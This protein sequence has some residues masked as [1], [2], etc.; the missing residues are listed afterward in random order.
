[1]KFQN[2][3]LI[4]LLLP[5]MVL[6]G[7]SKDEEGVPESENDTL[8]IS[9]AELVFM[10]RDTKKSLNIQSNSEWEITAEDDS[11]F[12]VSQTQG[13]G[14]VEIFIE[15]LENT[16]IRRSS[17][18]TINTGQLTKSVEIVQNAVENA[19]N[20][21]LM[22]A[23]I[24]MDN[25][26]SHMW[27]D[28]EKVFY[29]KYPNESAGKSFNF[30]SK[31]PYDRGFTFLWGFSSVFSGYNALTQHTETE[32]G[33][34]KYYNLYGDDLFDGLAVY[35]NSDKSPP[36]YASFGN[37][38]DDRY[39]DDNVWIGIDLLELSTHTPETWTLQKSKI[40]WNFIM[41]GR[42]DVLGDGVYW[43]EG[44]F[45]SKNTVSN[46]PVVV[47]GV[48]MYQ[49][50]QADQYL[51]TAKELYA[52]TKEN[53]QDPSDYLYWD[54]IRTADGSIDEAKY[55]YNSGQMMQAAVLLYQATGEQE[56][57]TDARNL[58]EACYQNF[59][60]NY[61]P[62]GG[63]QLRIVKDRHI[64]FSAIMFRG[65]VELYEVDNDPKYI[66]A[67][68]DSLDLAWENS[69]DPESGLFI[70]SFKGAS[71]S[72]VRNSEKVLLDQGGFIEMFARMYIVKNGIE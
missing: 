42:D 8:N 2:K 58:A 56:Y 46:A 6:T 9:K 34:E 72:T 62:Q 43:K 44:D 52:W 3:L 5:L 7:C 68:E 19:E 64:W 57:L 16:G 49:V 53:L 38:H 33:Y 71:E 11:W 13:Q 26:F 24:T 14:N 31:L 54:N 1:M 66:D 29:D 55:H 20:K 25:V 32:G 36:G 30:S 22:R 65:F 47:M 39:Y 67:Y 17:S 51:D 45:S 63:Q 59:F 69:R 61:T 12:S 23:E 41:S 60:E 70:G 50:T 48:K 37:G 21:F 28:T 4:I 18:L 27:N 40:V 15:P 10:A 35:D